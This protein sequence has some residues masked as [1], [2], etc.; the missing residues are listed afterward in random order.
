M[1]Q[2]SEKVKK[3]FAGRLD[4]VFLLALGFISVVAWLLHQGEANTAPKTV[5]V[6]VFTEPEQFFR[7]SMPASRTLVVS[8]KLGPAEIQFSSAGEYR[9]ASSTCPNHICVNY[10][11]VKNGSLVCVP[12]GIV[13][14]AEEKESRVDAVSR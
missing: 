14:V 1:V 6:R 9:I 2:D 11:W 7:V 4:V 5:S 8:G 13:V 10:G 12:N 3:I